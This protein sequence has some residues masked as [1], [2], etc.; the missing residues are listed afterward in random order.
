MAK[1]EEKIE[2]S[3]DGLNLKEEGITIVQPFADGQGRVFGM[4]NDQKIYIWHHSL[5]FKGRWVLYVN[6]DKKDDSKN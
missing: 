5:Y 2:R 4:G 3:K 1:K 6:E